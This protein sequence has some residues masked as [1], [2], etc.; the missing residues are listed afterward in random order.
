M[1]I[2]QDVSE[3]HKRLT[4]KD[5]CIWKEINIFQ[6]RTQNS[7]NEVFNPNITFYISSNKCIELID[8]IG[9]GR[10]LLSQDIITGTDATLP[11]LRV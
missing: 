1:G 10:H 8:N 3:G 4:A 7:E 11:K 5:L 6:L 9:L 2:L